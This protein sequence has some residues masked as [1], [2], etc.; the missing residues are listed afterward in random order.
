MKKWIR[1]RFR[2]CA[3]SV[4]VLDRRGVL[5][6][7]VPGRSAPA[8]TAWRLRPLV[9]AMQV[10]RGETSPIGHFH[11]GGHMNWP[12][13]RKQASQKEYIGPDRGAIRVQAKVIG[14]RLHERDDSVNV[15]VQ[16]GTAL[17]DVVVP[18][19]HAGRLPVGASLT[20]KL[21]GR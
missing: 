2:E 12:W 21:E 19:E 6:G 3:A 14:H 16:L 18:T 13:S 17:V 11:F 5:V 9:P 4:G 20:F 10:L 15:R 7:L 8:P 1:D